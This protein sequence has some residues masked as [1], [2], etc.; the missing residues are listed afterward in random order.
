MWQLESTTC[1]PFHREW[2]GFRRREI[3]QQESDAR[4][5]PDVSSCVETQTT[6]DSHSAARP[7]VKG[8]TT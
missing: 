4:V 1:T 5:R 2:A 7:A 8:V 3:W 6:A